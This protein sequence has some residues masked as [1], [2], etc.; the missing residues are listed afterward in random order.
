MLPY[1]YLILI[2]IILLTSHAYIISAIELGNDFLFEKKNQPEKWY[3]ISFVQPEVLVC[4]YCGVVKPS[5]LFPVPI[6][7]A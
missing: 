6:I 2:F 4:A 7:K 3:I 1:L 5:S